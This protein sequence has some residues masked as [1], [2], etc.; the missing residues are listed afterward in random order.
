MIPDYQK[1]LWLHA[2]TLLIEYFFN[3]DGVL[4]TVFSLY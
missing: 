3:I 4:K 1:E 2:S